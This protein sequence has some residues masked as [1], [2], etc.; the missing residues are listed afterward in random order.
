[1]MLDLKLNITMLHRSKGR[2]SDLD[3]CLAKV[4]RE[5][6]SLKTISNHR[7]IASQFLGSL[8]TRVVLTDGGH[9]HGNDAVWYIARCYF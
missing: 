5:S 2:Y 9:A 3:M 8:I 1:M 4:Q 7:L 6:W